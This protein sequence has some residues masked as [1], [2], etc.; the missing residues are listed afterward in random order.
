MLIVQIVDCVILRELEPTDLFAS[1]EIHAATA[2]TG[3]CIW[4]N[5]GVPGRVA[6]MLIVIGI[7]ADGCI[8]WQLD[9][10]TQ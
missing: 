9:Y 7:R 5:V 4:M 1:R 10:V 3:S 6:P 2:V 8:A